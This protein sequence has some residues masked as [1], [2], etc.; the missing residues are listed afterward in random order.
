MHIH[1]DIFYAVSA[2][3]MHAVQI[4]TICKIPLNMYMKL[5]Y[6]SN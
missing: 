6:I 1:I 5:Q 3:C 4:E 2:F